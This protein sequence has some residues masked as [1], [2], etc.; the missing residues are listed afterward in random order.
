MTLHYDTPEGL[1]KYEAEPTGARRE[2]IGTKIDTLLVPFELTVMAAVGLN[3]GEVKYAA[4][5]FEKGLS[6]RSLC[7]S[8]DRH[9]RA[10]MDGEE[11]DESSGLPHLALLASSVAMLCHNVMQGCVVDNRPAPKAGKSVAELA[12]MA[13]QMLNGAR[14]VST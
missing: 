7:N 14:H 8:I 1:E 2:S 3:Y 4:R 11:I 9:N 12:E 10:V 13:Q 6:Y 5:N